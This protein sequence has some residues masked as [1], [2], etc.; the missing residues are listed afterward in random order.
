VCMRRAGKSTLLRLI[1]GREKPA[2]GSVELGEYHIH[3]N[4]FEQVGR[5]R[6]GVG[7]GLG[8]WLRVCPALQCQAGA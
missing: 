8:A 5:R 3:P 4:Y 2:K 7:L 6:G 1:M